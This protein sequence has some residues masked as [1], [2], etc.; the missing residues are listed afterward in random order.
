MNNFDLQ[1]ELP[2]PDDNKGDKAENKNETLH[3]NTEETKE[4]VTDIQPTIP[5]LEF[6]DNSNNIQATTQVNQ[7]GV[8]IKVVDQ[9][10]KIDSVTKEDDCGKVLVSDKDRND[11]Y[12]IH[13]ILR[14]RERD[15]WETGS[16]SLFK[17][18]E[19]LSKGK[20]SSKDVK[21][22]RS[23]YC[24]IDHKRSG[25]NY[26]IWND[27]YVFDNP[28]LKEAE[29]HPTQKGP[30]REDWWNDMGPIISPADAWD[31]WEKNTELEEGLKRQNKIEQDNNE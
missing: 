8:S 3:A 16:W 22:L 17:I 14:K 6:E 11:A 23:K 15:G 27:K 31:R 21:R 9:E 29:H 26:Y 24:V 2:Y 5:N 30:E 4:S 28:K 12:L 18:A 19:S 1:P 13:N 7:E 25:K 10:D 20:L